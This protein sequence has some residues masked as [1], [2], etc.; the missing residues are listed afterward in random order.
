ML[1]DLRSFS[2]KCHLPFKV[3]FH[4]RSS[5]IECILPSKVVMHPRTFLCQIPDLWYNSLCENLGESSCKLLLAL[6]LGMC[7]YQ[8]Y[9][10]TTYDGTI[11]L[12][13]KFY[14]ILEDYQADHF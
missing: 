13:A 11:G 1:L 5:L 9:S 4:L 10:Y 7:Q 8:Y 6:A 2:N 12:L 14:P 3:I